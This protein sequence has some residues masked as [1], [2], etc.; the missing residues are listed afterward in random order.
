MQSERFCCQDWRSKPSCR[1]RPMNTA[2]P[3]GPLGADRQLQQRTSKKKGA[4]SYHHKEQNSD[5]SAWK[6]S[7]D[8][9][10]ALSPDWHLDCSLWDPE[11]RTLLNYAQSPDPK[12]LWHHK[13][14]LFS[15]ATCVVECYIEIK[16]KHTTLSERFLG[17]QQLILP[18]I[19]FFFFF[20]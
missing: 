20:F 3:Q 5:S 12:T 13:H 6:R 4:P 15:A 14:V 19:R 10:G 7:P 9:R 1:E 16:N 11:P 17:Y 2:E 18:K 8:L